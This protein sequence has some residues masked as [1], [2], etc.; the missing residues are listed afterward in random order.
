[1]AARTANEVVNPA[2]SIVNPAISGP[3]SPEIEYPTASRL[4]LW[5]RNDASPSSPVAFCAATWNVM[6]ATPT[7]AA[8]AN[9]AKQ[10]G[11]KDRYQ[12]T[13]SETNR[14]SQHGPA[15][16][17]TIGNP[18]RRNGAQHRQESVERD[19]YSNHRAGVPLLD[20]FQRH[21]DAVAGEDD[22]VG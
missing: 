11:D 6:N 12:R 19:Q 9:S 20:G 7:S 5:T 13:G 1:M 10:S 18:P 4:K 16:A 21:R 8:L 15:Y 22:V 3:R 14:A 2:W 17:D